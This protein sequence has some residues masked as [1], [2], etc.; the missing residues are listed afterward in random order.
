MDKATV[1]FAIMI[2]GAVMA[3]LLVIRLRGRGRMITAG[4][5]IG[6]IVALLNMLVEYLGSS[7]D[8]YHVAGPWTIISTPLPLTIGWVFMTFIY[9]TGY[10][11]LT[12][13]GRKSAVVVAYALIGIAIGCLTDYFFYAHAG[14]LTLGSNGSPAMIFIVWLVFIPLAIILY[15]LLL[16]F[17]SGQV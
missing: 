10:W 2:G 4:F 9:C 6:L 1:S 13:R 7:L 12:R 11:L 8:I 15:E 3:G 5:I 14:I 16:N 17:I